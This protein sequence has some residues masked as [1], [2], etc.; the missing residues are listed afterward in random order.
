MSYSEYNGW[1]N[2]GSFSENE[3]FFVASRRTI[4]PLIPKLTPTHPAVNVT[5]HAQC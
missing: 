3:L 5:R 4:P 2:S 1:S